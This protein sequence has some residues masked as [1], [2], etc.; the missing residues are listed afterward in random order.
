MTRRK[1]VTVIL[2]LGGSFLAVL[3]TLTQTTLFI[4]IQKMPDETA[5]AEWRPWMTEAAASCSLLLLSCGAHG[6]RTLHAN[7][8]AALLGAKLDDER[9]RLIFS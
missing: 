1:K 5:V 2:L 3:M 6:A 4:F 7:R 8:A 9:P